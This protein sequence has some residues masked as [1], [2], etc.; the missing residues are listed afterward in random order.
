[1]P[2]VQVAC[3]GVVSPPPHQ[4]NISPVGYCSEDWFACVHLPVKLEVAR[5]IPEA[6]AA[7]DA[8]FAKLE[9][10]STWDMSSVREKDD[11]VKEARQ[12]GTDVHFG[13]IMPLVFLKNAQLSEDQQKYKGRVVFRGDN[14]RDQDGCLAIFTEQGTSSSH[15]SAAKILDAIARLPGND[16]QDSDASGAYTQAELKGT[17]TWVRLPRDRWAKSWGN[18]YEKPV[19]KLRLALYGHPLAC[20]LYTSPSPRDS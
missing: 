12:K 20:L 5:G 18:K 6:K 4:D 13:D 2:C 9:G 19:V 16:G 17:E 11:V 10:K 15:L 8:E 1:M 14:I 3:S 7:L